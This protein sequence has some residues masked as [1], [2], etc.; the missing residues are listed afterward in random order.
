M[1]HGAEAVLVRRGMGPVL[2]ARLD[3]VFDFSLGHLP[4]LMRGLP[5]QERLVTLKDGPGMYG[6]AIAPQSERL[7]AMARSGPEAAFQSIGGSDPTIQRLVAKAVRLV[8][9]SIPILIT[10]KKGTGKER[11]VRAI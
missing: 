3:R 11:L 8:P 9:T 2:G 4:D 1:T 7:P 10:G 5:A 6:H